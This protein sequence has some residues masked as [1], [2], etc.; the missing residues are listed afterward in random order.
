MSKWQEKSLPSVARLHE[1]GAKYSEKHPIIPPVSIYTLLKLMCKKYNNEIA[2]D[3]LNT[4]FTVEELFAKV[5]IVAKAL[6]EF[7]LKQ[8]DILVIAMPNYYHGILAFM[9]ANKL[10]ATVTF[11]N[12]RSTIEEI[13]EYLNK[14]GS[15]IFMNYQYDE[16][17]NQRILDN[18][19]VKTIISLNDDELDRPLKQLEVKSNQK[20]YSFEEMMSLGNVSKHRAKGH[21]SSRIPAVILYTSGTTGKPKAVMLSNQNVIA[22]A[23][24][25]KNS[26]KVTD[27]RGE[28]SLVCVPFCYPYGFVTSVLMSLLCGRTVILGPDISKDNISYYMTKK[29]NIIFGSPALLALCMRNIPEGQ[30][31]SSV[32]TFISGGDYLNEKVANDALVFFEKH[33]CKVKIVNGSGNAETCG[34]NTNAYGHDLPMLSVG[35]P[36]IG[37]SAIVVDNELNELP[38]GEVGMLCLSGK[39]VFMGY[40]N[41]PELT[42]EAK[43]MYKGKEYIKTGTNGRLLSDGSFELTGRASRFYIISSLNK[44]YCDHVQQVLNGLEPVKMSAVVKKED[45]DNLYVGHAFIILEDGY[46]ASEELKRQIFESCKKEVIIQ[47]GDKVILKPYEIPVDITFVES[48]PYTMADKVDYLTLE[49]LIDSQKRESNY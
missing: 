40:Y 7:G 31:L 49:K 8:G 2:V 17:S 1:K 9:A 35:Y 20:I 13:E 38:Y 30:D 36:Y 22:T 4:S 47:S 23:I 24:Y 44:V 32:D 5:E 21:Y 25:L 27:K 19:K 45:K 14:Y 15:P 28:K 26:S 18:T 37:V 16:K 29:P 48:F 34:G 33:G 46:E 10:G 3:C 12:S 42:K 41:E 43:F 39:N 6:A 11:L